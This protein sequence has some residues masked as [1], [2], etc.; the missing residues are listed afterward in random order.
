M[1]CQKK[2]WNKF[3]VYSRKKDGETLEISSS[4]HHVSLFFLI[5]WKL[6]ILISYF[7]S[8]LTR[9]KDMYVGSPSEESTK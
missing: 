4:C 2:W 5:Y 9:N 8:L 1:P 6:I 3:K 7:K